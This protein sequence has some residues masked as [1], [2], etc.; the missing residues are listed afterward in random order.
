M[1]KIKIQMKMSAGRAVGI[2][3]RVAIMLTIYAGPDFRSVTPPTILS[4]LVLGRRI[5]IVDLFIDECSYRWSC[6]KGKCSSRHC[7][8]VTQYNPL[9]GGL[10]IGE[11]LVRYTFMFKLNVPN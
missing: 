3:S 1:T 6:R 8:A 11:T 4:I 9:K 2:H 5:R 7:G 10:G